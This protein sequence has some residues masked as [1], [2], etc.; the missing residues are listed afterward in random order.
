[1]DDLAEAI[2]YVTERYENTD[3]NIGNGVETSV[4]ELAQRI[5]KLCGRKEPLQVKHLPS[6]TYDVQRRVP[7][8]SKILATGWRPKINLDEGLSRTLAWIQ[9]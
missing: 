3:F 9:Q 1:V 8:V 5:W 6:Y 7:D 4:Q 2:I